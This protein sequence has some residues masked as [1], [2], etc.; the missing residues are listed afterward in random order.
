[1]S[2]I[3]CV[4][5]G[6]STT[7]AVATRFATIVRGAESPETGDDPVVD[8]PEGRDHDEADREAEQLPFEAAVQQGGE[9]RPVGCRGRVEVDHE[10]RHREGVDRVEERDGARELDA[11][12]RVV[13]LGGRRFS[14]HDRSVPRAA[15][16][17]AS[18]S[19]GCRS[20]GAS[21]GGADAGLPR[22]PWIG[23]ALATPD[24][25]E[26][27]G[28]GRRR[29]VGGGPGC[30]RPWTSASARPRCASRSDPRRRGGRRGVGAGARL[31][32]RPA[33]SDGCRRGRRLRR[34]RRAIRR[35]DGGVG[36]RLGSDGGRG[37]GGGARA[38]TVRR[39]GA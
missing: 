9:A 35:A 34:G 20:A 10:Q 3:P 8:P 13:P 22:H 27:D 39:T 28:D 19:P 18:D 15:A 21:M 1:M 4:V 2:L 31:V 32:D 29:R 26:L 17:A 14:A 11:V 37:R 6:M 33:G 24:G 16:S 12:A 30:R 25:W 7:N 23:Y 36:D 5:N 38:R